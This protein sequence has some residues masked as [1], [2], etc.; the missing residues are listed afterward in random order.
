M[1]TTNAV[2]PT[3][4]KRKVELELVRKDGETYFSF[5]VDPK[6]TEIYKKQSVEIKTSTSWPNLKFYSIP[7]LTAST[8][9]KRVLAQYSLFD[10]YGQA[11]VK[12]DSQSYNGY[13]FN[14]AWLRTESGKGKVLV[15]DALTIAELSRMMKQASEFLKCHFAEYFQDATI[16]GIVSIEL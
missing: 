12:S 10:D 1:P 7:S 8:E 3:P 13:R 16:K 11:I 4:A 6:I 5:N 15:S 2:S 14:I 9:Y